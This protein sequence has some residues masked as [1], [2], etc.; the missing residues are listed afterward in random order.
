MWST[1]GVTAVGLYLEKFAGYLVTARVLERKGT[2]RVAA[3]LPVAL[4][5]SIVAVQVV[6]SGRSVQL[7]A[8]LPGIVVAVVLLARRTNFLIMVLAASTTTALVR[9]LGWMT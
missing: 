5:A 4:L 7:D 6:A 3:L 8:R 1:I 2:Q 9:H